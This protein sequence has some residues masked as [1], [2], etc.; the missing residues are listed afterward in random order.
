MKTLTPHFETAFDFRLEDTLQPEDLVLAASVYDYDKLSADD[1][2]GMVELEIEKEFSAGW[3]HGWIEKEWPLTD[4]RGEMQRTADRS[5]K[6]QIR[7][8]LKEGRHP[9]GFMRLK[10]QF[11][12]DVP[13]APT[14]LALQAAPNALIGQHEIAVYLADSAGWHKEPLNLL[15]NIK[16]SDADEEVQP[17]A[18]AA[19]PRTLADLRGVINT[20]T[21]L[22]RSGA[23]SLADAFAAEE[24]QDLEEPEEP[25]EPDLGVLQT[26]RLQLSRGS[27]QGSAEP[28]DPEEAGL[29]LAMAVSL[30]KR[31]R[32]RVRRKDRSKRVR[33]RP[34]TAGGP[35]DDPR[36][37]NSPSPDRASRRAAVGV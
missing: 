37:R 28:Q 24:I 10:L 7:K 5:V 26:P 21:S 30:K 15:I 1:F 25:Q 36:R 34:P 16:R 22:R 4:A 32:T 31:V 23:Q 27:R 17:T 6:K 19:A 3:G 2:L 20:L 8:R 33:E 12:A 35:L 14:Q 11:I 18:A 29:S 13:P 9:Y